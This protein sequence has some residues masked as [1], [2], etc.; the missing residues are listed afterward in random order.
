M[1]PAIFGVA[2]LMNMLSAKSKSKMLIVFIG[3]LAVTLWPEKQIG[4][5][6]T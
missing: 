5:T 1:S 2:F 6:Q 3:V 4:Q